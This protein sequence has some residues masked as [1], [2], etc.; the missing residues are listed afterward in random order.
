MVEI[1]ENAPD[2]CI[3]NQDEEDICLKDLQGKWVV[4][5][6]YPK[7]STPGC[8]LEAIAFSNY[9][10]E[11]ERLNTVVLGISPDSCES[12]K[13]FQN[14]H[15]LTVTLLSDPTH[16]VLEKYEVWKPK[17]LYGREF[18]GVIRSTFLID[19]SGKIVFICNKV[20]VKGHIE[21]VLETVKQ[22]QM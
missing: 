21:T 2:F 3:K 5:Y 7:D 15:D 10:D 1:N 6:C 11:F 19:P 18:F 9:H 4:L 16:E 17:K 12:H 14:K 13:K 8:T 22:L 20:K